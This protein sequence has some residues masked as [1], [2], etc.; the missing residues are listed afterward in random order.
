LDNSLKKESESKDKILYTMEKGRIAQ[1]S[2]NTEASLSNFSVAI[3]TIQEKDQKAVVSAS[4]IGANIASAAVND[5]AIPYEAK[6]YE[7]VMLH[8]YQAMNYLTQKDI[9]GAGVEV[10]W[11]NMEQEEALSRH[12]RELEKAQEVAEE[13]KISDPMGN[14]ELNDRYAAL[15]EIAGKVKNSFQNAYTFYIS[16]LI[17]E[18]S[19]QNNDAYI[20]YKKALEIY[21][22]NKYLRN[23]V[24]R[25]AKK[26]QMENDLT[27]FKVKY[28]L[29]SEA[30]S[31]NE[32]GKGE[33]IV[34]FEDGFVP[35][36]QEV[37][38]PLPVPNAGI[39]AIAFPIYNAKPEE[40]TPLLLKGAD[41]EIGCTDTICDIRA[42]AVKSL[43]EEIPG[44]AIRQ[45]IRAITKGAATKLAKEKL[46]LL[47][48]L[49]MS[50]WNL[51]SE[52]ADLRSWLT[53]PANAQILRARLPA[54]THTLT[55]E[56]PRLVEPTAIDVDINEGGKTIVHVVSAG[57]QLYST[58]QKF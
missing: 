10:R 13:K 41:E 6:G 8:H 31:D 7:R 53:L 50:A 42:L 2:K 24:I 49:T 46:G 4:K 44:I 54:G 37:K 36:K 11:A 14:Q 25:L 1:F 38:I 19:G 15:D 12:Q 56:H 23:D 22:D 45:M 32:T 21:P 33:I 28:D 39:I 47:G 40:A 20:D 16:G 26:L 43:K 34:L 18:I 27:E 48:S 51:V 29:N 58:I 57:N 5:N 17:Y 3:A 52:N 9:E 35:Q 55:L 30:P